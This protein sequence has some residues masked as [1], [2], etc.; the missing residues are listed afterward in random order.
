MFIEFT[1]SDMDR[2][3]AQTTVPFLDAQEVLPSVLVP[4]SGAGIFYKGENYFGGFIA[5][6]VITYDFSKHLKAAFLE[7]EIH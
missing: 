2:D 6:K 1:H 5:P 7:E 3:A 4:L